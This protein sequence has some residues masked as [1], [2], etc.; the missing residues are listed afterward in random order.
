MHIE[1]KLRPAVA[2]K[3]EG[4]EIPINQVAQHSSA[5]VSIRQH[6]SAYVSIRQ[7]TP[8]F[9]S[10][11]YLE[12]VINQIAQGRHGVKETGDGLCGYRDATASDEFVGQ[13][14]DML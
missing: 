6:T 9:V 5:Y 1:R 13:R 14:H 4:L 10:S 7:H 11:A 8:A 3:G 2:T 12:I